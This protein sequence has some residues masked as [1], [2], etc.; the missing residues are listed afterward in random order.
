MKRIYSLII[1]ALS[2][3]LLFSCLKSQE[4][5]FEESSAIR[6]QKLI[7]SY[8]DTLGSAQK[9]WILQYYPTPER[10]YGGFDYWLKFDNDQMVSVYTNLS[11]NTYGLV[12][13]SLYD[14]ISEQGP[15]LTFNTYN[16]LMHYFTTPTSRN[17]QAYQSDYE[18]VIQGYKDGIFTLKGKKYGNTMY[19]IRLDDDTEPED[20]LDAVARNSSMLLAGDFKCK[21][22]NSMDMYFESGAEISFRYF[23][24][25]DTTVVTESFALTDKGFDLY[26]EVDIKGHKMRRFE[27]DYD[28]GSYVCRDNGEEIRFE[29]VH[30]DS[31]MSY[32]DLLGEYWCVCSALT[33]STDIV[34]DSIKCTFEAVDGKQSFL[35]D[36]LVEVS[37]T[38]TDE[39]GATVSVKTYPKIKLRYDPFVGSFAIVSQEIDADTKTWILGY[40]GGWQMGENYFLTY[41]KGADGMFASNLG[42]STASRLGT[43]KIISSS[44]GSTAVKISH[45]WRCMGGFSTDGSFVIHHWNKIK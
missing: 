1:L 40:S 4:D 26:K 24:G 3:S 31:Y 15:L 41:T 32:D 11:I 27:T 18:F 6:I 17:Y 42:Y 2:S 36:S 5:L 39:N 44:S 13:T 20:Y 21:S 28:E 16:D 7:R 29:Y 8:K 30:P 43:F 35:A 25:Q 12:Y 9:G 33:A 14:I 10:S 19:L 37:K 38:V 23:E 45:N 34:K 22:D